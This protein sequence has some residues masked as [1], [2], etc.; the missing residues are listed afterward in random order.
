MLFVAANLY[1]GPEY[2]P[3]ILAVWKNLRARVL[4]IFPQ[5]HVSNRNGNLK[6]T[7]DTIEMPGIK[8]NGIRKN[9]AK[10]YPLT[11]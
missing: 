5:I 1:P 9:A 3:A 2:F 6:V 7:I 4:S 11:E 10:N 8:A